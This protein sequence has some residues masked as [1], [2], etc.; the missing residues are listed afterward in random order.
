MTLEITLEERLRR[1]RDYCLDEE[2]APLPF[3]EEGD[4][5]ALYREMVRA[6]HEGALRST[7]RR[8]AQ[9]LGDARFAALVLAFLGSGGIKTRYFWR[10]PLLFYQDA[11]SA[12]AEPSERELAEYEMLRWSI[13]HE[14]AP[15]SSPPVELDFEKRPL[16]KAPF[17]LLRA[18]DLPLQVGEAREEH[19]AASPGPRVFLFYRS[20]DERLRQLRLSESA[21]RIIDELSDGKKTLK[22]AIIALS[23]REGFAIDAPYLEKLSALLATLVEEG[24]LLGSYD[25]ASPACARQ[26]EK[27]R[28]EKR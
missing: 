21:A 5:W 3:S 7:Y 15:R 14:E 28:E 11:L 26:D 25:D 10:V 9:L 19:K 12:L 18:S 13:R 4:R 2:P 20:A 8:S 16:F 22:D 23:Q 24:F 1:I 17:A 6:R 27:R